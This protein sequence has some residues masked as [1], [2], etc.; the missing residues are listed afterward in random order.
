[1]ARSEPA[2]TGPI[3][4]GRRQAIRRL[5]AGALGAAASP[6]WVQPLIALARSH[7]D[8]HAAAADMSAQSWTPAVFTP[9]QNDAVTALTELII[10]ATDT[11]G[12][13][14]ALVNRFIDRVLADAPAPQRDGFLRGL[15]WMDT[16]SRSA[17]GAAIAD[18]TAAQQTT[19][20]TRIADDQNHA[21]ADAAG[22]EFFKVLK[23]MTISGY[24]STEI[25][26]RQELGDD[27]VLMAVEF[28]GC[29]HPEHQG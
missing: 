4:P 29:D 27:G 5:A 22:V 15:A 28:H 19:L 11:P 10:P 2:S 21:A 6:L 14:D 7:A 16:A 17:F 3:V 23:S 20:L 24:Y 25:G 13:K 9:R 1:V 12:A 8:S 18:A 26:L